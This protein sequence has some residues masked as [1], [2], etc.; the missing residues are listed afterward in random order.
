MIR[1]NLLPQKKR[2]IEASAGG[3][4]WVLWIVLAVFVQVVGLWFYQ[5]SQEEIL[6]EE[7]R[8]NRVLQASIAESKAKISNHQATKDELAR[9]RAREEAIVQLQ[10]ARTGPTAILLELSRLLSP[11]QAPTTDAATLATIRKNRPLAAYNPTWDTRRLWLTAFDEKS[12]LLRITGM[13]RD[14]EDVAELAKRLNLSNFFDNVRFLP[15]KSTV[16]FATKLDL[17]S[18]ALE[19]KVNY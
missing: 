10:M 11:G 17:V 15:A 19:A 12:K 3:D 5:G 1:I 16:D 14:A 13:A 4:T 9:L 8:K 2:R 6:A 18:F 7:Q